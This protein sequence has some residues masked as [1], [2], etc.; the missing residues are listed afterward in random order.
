MSFTLNYISHHPVLS[1]IDHCTQLSPVTL[2]VSVCIYTLFVSVFIT[3]SL[4]NVTTL[5]EVCFLACSRLFL[6]LLLFWTACMVLTL[7]WTGFDPC[8][9]WFTNSDYPNKY[10]DWIFSRVCIVTEGLRHA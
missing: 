1:L 8:L 2:L 10:C 9:D 3:E 5:L 6:V 7:A 4:F